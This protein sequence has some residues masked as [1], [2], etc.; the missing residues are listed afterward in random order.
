MTDGPTRENNLCSACSASLRYRLQA[1]AIAATYGSP[2]LAL[3]ELVETPELSGLT[4]YEPGISGPL[5]RLLSQLDGYFASYLWPDVEQGEEHQGVRCEDL[6]D[7]TLYD[8]SV[9]LVVSSDVFEHVRGPIEA[10]AELFR[11]LRPG[12][13]HIFTVPLRWPLPSTTEPRVDYS[14]PEDVFLV[15]PEY[16]GSPTDP[17]GS[18]VY[19][20]FGMDVPEQLREIGFET[21]THHGYRMAVTFVSRKPPAPTP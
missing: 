8:E 1:S 11:V 7:L 15:T 5:K 13:H 9:D 12:G 4:V 6:R 14:G 18:L 2:D 19:T 17:N 10:F 21:Q 16:H 3:R 20:D